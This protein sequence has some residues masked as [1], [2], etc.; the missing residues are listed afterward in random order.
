MTDHRDMLLAFRD[1]MAAEGIKFPDAIVADG[2]IHRVRADDDKPGRRN[3]WYVLHGDERP[4][5][6]FGSWKGG[7]RR[8][9]SAKGV[10]PMSEAERKEFARAAAERQ[11]AREAKIQADHAHAAALAAEIWASGTDV[12]EHPYL[13]RKGVSGAGLRVGVW[14]KEWVTPEGELKT[15]RTPNTLLIRL[16]DEK[17]ATWALQGIHAEPVKIGD[18]RREKDFLTGSRKRG[19]WTSIGK[20]TKVDGKRTVVICEGYATGASIHEATGLA[21]LVAFD[22]GNLQ[23]V[24]ETARR[25]MLDVRILLAADNDQWTESPVKNPGITRASEAAAAID[26]VVVW[27]CFSELD[28]KPTDFNDLH[29]REGLTAVREQILA[30]WQSTNASAVESFLDDPIIGGPQPSLVAAS[31]AAAPVVEKDA[32]APELAEEAIA[33]NFAAE[34]CGSLRYVAAW[35]QW[36]VWTGSVWVADLTLDAFNRVRRACRLAS[37]TSKNEGQA[38]AIASHKTAA[39]VDR[40]SRA[41]RRLAATVDQWDVDA[42][43][44]NTPGGVVD[45]RT[46]KLRPHR[47]DDFMTMITSVAPG[48]ECPRWLALVRWIG[49][50]DAEYAAYLQRIAGYLLTGSTAEH[51]LFFLHGGG[52]NGKGTFTNTLTGILNAYAKVSPMETFTES[53]GE[54]HPTDLAGFRG[55]RLVTAQETEAER[56]WTTSR[57]NRS[58]SSSS[59][60]T[61]GPHSAT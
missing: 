18:D 44:L 1:A 52:G 35:G 23:P 12:V 15:F 37:Q 22:A 42:W 4:A 6:A 60:E 54:R 59:R 55:A 51:A 40:L 50:D 53:H 39:A 25:F 24:A 46:G 28:G 32:R 20:P 33:L 41:D 5:G 48:G 45:L 19:L 61:T 56:H 13:T 31:P 38:R 17:N 49:G 11:A 9:W 29:T 27:P 8:T 34:H 30:A 3:A 2:E 26:G 43:L 16:R 57:I 47:S 36:R 7:G 21:V 58:S 10:K 14:V